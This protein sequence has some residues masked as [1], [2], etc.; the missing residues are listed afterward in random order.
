MFYLKA[1]TDGNAE[2][3]SSSSTE[4]TETQEAKVMQKYIFFLR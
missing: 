3:A 2:K 4:T 1:A